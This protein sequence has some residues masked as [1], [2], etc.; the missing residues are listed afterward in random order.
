MSFAG[1]D[2]VTL[3]ACQTAV[4]DRPSFGQEMENLAATVRRQKAAAVLGTLWQ[5]A[6]TSTGELMKD[7][8]TFKGEGLSKAHALQ[9]AQQ[10]MLNTA[11]KNDSR[12]SHPYFWA[13]FVLMG[14]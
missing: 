14:N 8:Y 5:V 13:P 2:R 6:D 1:I 3:S 10:K 11:T 4:S 9:K 7:F 12:W